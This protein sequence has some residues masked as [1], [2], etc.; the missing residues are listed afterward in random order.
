MSIL[1]SILVLL[2]MP[3]PFIGQTKISDTYIESRV[4]IKNVRKGSI[5]FNT[6]K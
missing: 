4:A 2:L 1:I 6:S 5:K 3:K